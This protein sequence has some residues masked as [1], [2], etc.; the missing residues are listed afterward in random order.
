MNSIQAR[1]YPISAMVPSLMPAQP[2]GGSTK[3]PS[4]KTDTVVPTD[5]APQLSA[6]V[7]TF[8]TS[9]AT[10]ETSGR[11]P[12]GTPPEGGTASAGEAPR[13]NE[14]SSESTSALLQLKTD[15]DAGSNNSAGESGPQHAPIVFDDARTYYPTSMY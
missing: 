13:Q 9:D 5:A 1:S 2:A 6:R 7:S 10:M 11:R 15:N 4:P 12:K 3:T 14:T 8:L